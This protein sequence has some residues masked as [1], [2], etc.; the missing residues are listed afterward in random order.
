MKYEIKGANRS[1]VIDDKGVRIEVGGMLNQSR[2]IPY[3]KLVAVSVKK[4][5]AITAGHIF[6]QTAADGS[7]PLTSLNTVPFRGKETY[8]LACQIKAAVEA[9]MQEGTACLG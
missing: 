8:E 2:Y 4:P 1:A 6:F 5:G 3:G 7:N 9:K